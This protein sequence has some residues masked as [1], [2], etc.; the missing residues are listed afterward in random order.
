MGRGAGRDKQNP[1]VIPET[2]FNDSSHYLNIASVV[3]LTMCKQ[4]WL[5]LPISSTSPPLSNLVLKGLLGKIDKST[6]GP[7]KRKGFARECKV[8]VKALSLL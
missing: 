5:P 6:K 7:A 2:H 8:S 4:E 3:R 1:R